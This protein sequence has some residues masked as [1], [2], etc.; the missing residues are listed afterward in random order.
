MTDAAEKSYS[1]WRE[2]D[3]MPTVPVVR[4]TS[5]FIMWSSRA[6]ILS[7]ELSSQYWNSDDDKTLLFN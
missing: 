5:Q 7:V 3:V 6:F 4:K 1:L 2:C